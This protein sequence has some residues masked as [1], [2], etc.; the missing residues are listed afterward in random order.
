MGLI[1]VLIVDDH[2]SVMEGTRA[3]LEKA[4]DI[5]VTISTSASEALSIIP[6]GRFDVMLFDLYMPQ[7]NGLEL[8]KE[9]LQTT[10]NA[11]ILIYTGYDI[12]PHFNL[13][14]DSGVSGFVSK[15][16]TQDQLVTAIRCALRGE[17]VLPLGLLK[18]LR[19]GTAAAGSADKPEATASITAKDIEIL[20]HLA[21]GKSNREIADTMLMSQRSLE[22]GLTQIFQRLQVK[23]RVEAVVKAKELKILLSDDFL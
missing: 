17:V 8:A 11:V 1:R 10:P 18:E 2:P 4:G 21:K 16:A 9:V 12:T 13:F 20:K 7:M 14:M 22:Y 5:D 23:S 15:T 6:D 3:M 19:R